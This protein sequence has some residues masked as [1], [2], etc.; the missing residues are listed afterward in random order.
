MADFVAVRSEGGLLPPDLLQRIAGN[1]TDLGGLAPKEY[2]LPENDRL[3]EAAARAWARAKTYWAAFQAAREGLAKDETGVTQTREQW[4]LPLLREL[5]YRDVEFRAAAEVI[6]SRRYSLSHRSGPIPLHLLSFRQDLDRVFPAVAGGLRTSPHALLQDYLNRSDAVYGIVSNGLLLRLVRDNAALTRQAFVEFD[7]A[8]MLEGGS[9]ADFVLLFLVLHRSRLPRPDAAASDCW[10]ERWRSK[11]ETQ[12]ARALGALRLG[13]AHA[14]TALGSGFLEHPANAALRQRLQSGALTEQA[15][16]Q[17]LLRLVY[18]FIFLFVAEERDLIFPPHASADDRRR[19]RDHYSASRLRP[20]TRKYLS[21]SRH[22]DLWRGLQITFGLLSG[23]RQGLGVAA[24]GGGLF[25]REACPDL[26]GAALR[27]NSLAEAVRH[28]SWVQVSKVTRRVSY[29]DM[30]TEELGGVYE[31]LLE[32]EPRVLI[33][34]EPPRFELAASGQRKLTGSYYTPSS[35][36]QE[37][38]KSALDPVIAERLAGKQTQQARREALLGITVCDAACGSG[39]FLLA[40]ARRLAQE[41]AQ[42]DAGDVEPGR[43]QMRHALREVIRH[44]I[45]GVDMNP[46]AVDL[47]KLALWLEGHEPGLPMSFLDHRIKLG[48]SLVGATRD[49]ISEGIPSGAYDP[50]SGDN[51][52]FAKS[53]ARQNKGQSP[54][55]LTLAQG[56]AVAEAEQALVDAVERIGAMP[57]EAAVAVHEQRT[58]YDAFQR[59]LLE[60]A[61]A[62][63]D[64]WTAAFFWPLTKDAPPPPTT[65]ALVSIPGQLPPLTAP[66]QKEVARLRAR[67]R[68]FHW[69]LEFP[70]VFDRGGFDCVLGNPPWEKVEMDEEEFFAQREPEIAS[71]AGAKRK[72]AIAR[73]E[74]ENPILWSHF[75]QASREIACTTKFARLSNRFSLTGS[76]RINLYALFAEHDR[77]LLN[78]HGRT[79][80]IVSTGIATD[81]STKRFFSDLV[82]RDAIAKLIGFENESFI[83]PGVHHSYKFCTLTM[84]GDEVKVPR[85]DLAFLIRHYEQIDDVARHFELSREDFALLNPNTLTCPVFRTKID[86]DLTKAI[87]RRMP[88]LVDERTGE[89]PW[90]VSFMQGLFNMTSDSGL[91]HDTPGAG[92]VPL[93]EAKLF[94]QYNHRWATYEGATTRDPTPAELA[95]PAWQVR[96]R[97]WVDA[98]QVEAQL[99]GR[100]DRGWLLAFRDITNAIGERTA[101]FSVLPRIAVGHTAPIV[102]TQNTNANHIACLLAS[103]SCLPWDYIVR[104]KVGGN[105]LTFGFVKQFPV[106][107]CEAY[108]L[109]DHDFITPRVLEITYTAHDLAPFARD[110]GYTGP[111]SPGMRSAVSSSAPNS[112]PIT[113]RSTV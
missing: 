96:P 18:R 89:N 3:G 113:P 59:D 58:A 91:F 68:F 110:M 41:L 47:C 73:L 103:F 43:E 79:G 28:L 29:R 26:D 40:A 76:G 78:D 9:Y 25:D 24:L 100:W 7:L 67:H 50:V 63:L 31:G 34:S 55:Q 5:G 102:L 86:A 45:Y 38:I 93:Y 27:N 90:G 54:R 106:L 88:V 83:F 65:S 87:Y 23:E 95:N 30:D 72:Q 46:L 108:E 57:E 1:D 13:V 44:G 53:I 16:Y 35:L 64:V 70:D 4:L 21:D 36:V 94:H 10:L 71:L 112:T 14:I 111:L 81:D 62:A 92:R 82:E 49:L 39:H 75:A 104:Q 37:L 74:A 15:Y 66:Q 19:Y 51:K 8:A 20:V 97:Y 101:I 2:G 109:A 42:I 77:A 105:H 56:A 61:R 84:T 32:Q 33:Q 60:P 52:E 98:A 6:D 107:P 85:A 22:D 48:N 99:A 12:G 11:A 69:R 80:V 17:Q